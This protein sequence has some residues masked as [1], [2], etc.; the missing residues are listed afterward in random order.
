MPSSFAVGP[1]AVP[2]GTSGNFAILAK[3]GISTVPL[4]TIGESALR[5]LDYLI[6]ETDS[7][8]SFDLL[9]GNIAVSPAAGTYMTVS[10]FPYPHYEARGQKLESC[11]KYSTYS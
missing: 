4:S 3:T 2:L 1:A 5:V 10:P 8:D 6:L 7:V 11:R 9:V